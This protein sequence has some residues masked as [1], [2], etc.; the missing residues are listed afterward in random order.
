M[1]AREAR[2]EVPAVRFE[3]H[4][5][6]ECPLERD[7]VANL[8]GKAAFQ[9]ESSAERVS[10]TFTV[11]LS[12]RADARSASYRGQ[13][14]LRTPGGAPSIR[15][16]TGVNCAEVAEAVAV[17]IAIELAPEQRAP[18]RPAA[19][20]SPEET[21]AASP[22]PVRWKWA[23][24]AGGGF[25]GALSD[26][27]SVE[28]RLSLALRRNSTAL[29]SPEFRAG[30][31]YADGRRVENEGGAIELR[32][33]GVTFEGCPMR[34]RLWQ[35]LSLEPCG[36]VLLAVRAATGGPPSNPTAE[37]SMGSWVD[38]G[39]LL[40][41]LYDI[42]NSAWIEIS[43]EGFAPMVRDRFYTFTPSIAVFGVPGAGA[44]GAFGL[45]VHF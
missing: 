34:A 14:L 26:A 8:R 18:T 16:V 19:N 11:M 37:S 25:T 24:A 4:A 1:N 38:I 3:Y 30:F 42:S 31:V 5:G 17:V 2:A 12:K 41:A 39:G 15:E 20:E 6:P 43:A 7:F 28:G 40:R 10:R 32:L 29:L 23:V 9:V 44:R 27:V 21:K 22:L 36:K 35:R 13:L 45:G 33:F